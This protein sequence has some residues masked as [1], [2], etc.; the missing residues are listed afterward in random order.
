MYRL[1]ACRQRRV[2][3]DVKGLAP[4]INLT[5]LD[6]SGTKVEGNVKDLAPLINLTVLGLDYTNVE[7]AG[8]YYTKEEIQAAIRK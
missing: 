2:A 4:L 5:E 7:G 3:G 6:L 8:F 1:H